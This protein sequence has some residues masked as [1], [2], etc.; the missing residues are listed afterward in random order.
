MR[1]Q[2]SLF[3]S[4]I[5][6]S[7]F[8]SAACGSSPTAV[9]TSGVT[10]EGT[11]ASD[12][13]GASSAD[14]SAQ[15]TSAGS[16]A[17]RVSIEGTSRSVTTDAMGRFRLTGAP[18]GTATLRFE[19]SG[20]DAR[21]RIDGLVDGQVLTITVAVSGNSASLISTT[22][23][24]PG[25]SA[26]PVPSPVDVEFTGAI[27]SLSPP[28]MVVAGRTVETG[29]TTNF[30][31]PGNIHSVAD[32]DVGDIVRVEGFINGDG[33]VFAREVERLK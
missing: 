18:D 27:E 7:A 22:G 11:V 19:G 14:V 16:K 32:L 15:S 5:A 25:N 4:A 26:G 9:E 28:S 29:S 17:L 12:A 13:A 2:Q 23:R 8:W 30:E 10:I 20:V 3:L 33:N 1:L 21:L 31:G 24:A 6:F